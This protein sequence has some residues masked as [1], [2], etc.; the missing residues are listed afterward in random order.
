LYPKKHLNKKGSIIWHC[1]CECGTEFDVSYNEL[2][3]CN[4][5]SCG[6]R[7][8]KHSENLHSYLT[9]VDGTSVDSLKSKKIPT[10]NT[11]GVKGVYLIKGKWVPKIVFQKKQYLLGKYDTLQEAEEKRQE[12]EHILF[13]GAVAHYEKWKAKADENP[14]WAKENPVEI[15]V[16][17]KN[18]SELDVT[19]LPVIEEIK[20]INR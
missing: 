11:T 19:F 9:H 5:Q 1:R 7:K 12:A 10:D 17:K 6:C 2:V 14:E 3:Y 13:D 8:K 16:E 18:G 4:Q 15:I 20:S